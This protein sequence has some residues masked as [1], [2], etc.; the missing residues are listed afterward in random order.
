M[1]CLADQPASLFSAA[2]AHSRLHQAAVVVLSSIAVTLKTQQQLEDSLLPYLGKHVQHVDTLKVCG[3][4][5]GL[6]LLQLPS[7]LQ[8]TS[9][10]LQQLAVQLQPGRGFQGVLRPEL[11]L[12]Q[13]RLDDCQL[14]DYD[15]AMAL[16]AVLSLLPGLEHLSIGSS[17]YL[18][19]PIGELSLLQ[20]LTYLR[21]VCD[22]PGGSGHP[23]TLPLQ[24]L[25]R[26]VDLRVH[27]TLPW[28]PSHHSAASMLSCLCSLT[29]LTLPDAALDPTALAGK[30]QL[31]HLELPCC[32]IAGA[33]AGVAQLLSKLQ[34]LTQL[35]HLDLTGTLRRVEHSNPPAAAFSALTASSML[36]HLSI[37]N[38]TVP[39]GVWQGMFP[40]GRQLQH[41]RALHI[42]RVETPSNQFVAP[43]AG[44]SLVRCCPG[45]QS[46]DLH[47]LP[48]SQELLEAVQGF[49]ALH[50][51]RLGRFIGATI[52]GKVFEP[53]CRLTGLRELQLMQP[54]GPDGLLLL[55]QLKQLTK[56][57]IED[58][59]LQ[60]SPCTFEVGCCAVAVL[61]TVLL[62]CICRCATRSCQPFS[63]FCVH[64]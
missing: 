10:Q 8:L 59:T 19:L 30:T 54:C 57:L 62:L 37:R 27:F 23:A 43:P 41:L 28:P 63:A 49:S 11:L 1:H 46:L 50:T 12:K 4:S 32:S 35:T 56:L 21:L 15:S 39:A 18:P 26:V 14:H 25:T 51:L 29:R 34:E 36:Q 52:S 53:L 7:K 61:H 40:A 9:L 48:C 22:L 45:L 60:W 42:S 2:R 16:A 17:S 55:T 20:Q 33:A 31:Q 47:Y 13:L 58:L 5:F 24:A 64:C 38:C 44:S 3:C 6:S